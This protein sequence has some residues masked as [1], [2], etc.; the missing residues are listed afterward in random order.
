MSNA[1]VWQENA[2]L[3][4][5]VSRSAPRCVLVEAFTRRVHRCTLTMRL[6]VNGVEVIR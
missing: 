1:G 4:V 5:S 6:A 3:W 2:E